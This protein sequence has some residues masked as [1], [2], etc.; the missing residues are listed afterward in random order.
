MCKNK[1]ISIKF[2]NLSISSN[3]LKE[4]INYMLD[5]K[6]I[7][8]EHNFFSNLHQDNQNYLLSNFKLTSNTKTQDKIIEED[9]DDFIMC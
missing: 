6:E 1:T 2:E 9:D 3:T 7:I 5:S 4:L 8:F